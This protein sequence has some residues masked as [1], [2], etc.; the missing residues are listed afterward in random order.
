MLRSFSDQEV[1]RQVRR[2]VGH[3]N[4][5]VRKEALKSLLSYCDPSA[6]NLL[7]QDLDCND[8]ARKLAAVQIADMSSNPEVVRKLLAILNLSGIKDYGLEIKTAAVQ[9]LAGI[10][11]PLA[12][13]KLKEIIFSGSFLHSSKHNQLKIVILRALP[14]FP[15]SLARPLLEEIKAA[16]DKTLSPIAVEALKGLQGDET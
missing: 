2:L 4:P 16:G 6:D 1:Q 12:L 7:L 10:G 8:P 15:S 13:P 11:A 3:Y 14:R 5:I 9:A